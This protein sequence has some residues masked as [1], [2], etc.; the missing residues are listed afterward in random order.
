MAVGLSE[1]FTFTTYK[2]RRNLNAQD[3]F[4]MRVCMISYIAANRV[5]YGEMS[6]RNKPKN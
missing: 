6:E 3:P 1:P 5:G 4:F 2:D